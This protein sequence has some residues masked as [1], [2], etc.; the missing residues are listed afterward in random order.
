MT[1]RIRSI[2]LYGRDVDKVRTLTFRTSGLN[3]ITG[4][5]A[6][7]K[8]ALIDI[9]DYCLAS[10][11][12]NVP[13]GVIR[14]HVSK[15]ALEIETTQG[16][17][18]CA[19]DEPRQGK[20]TTSNMHIGIYD[21]SGPPDR[22]RLDPNMSLAA[23]RTLLSSLAD[24]EEN[25]TDSGESNR[26]EFA[27][28]IRHSLYF[29]FQG[30]GEIAD[31]RILFH[32]Q[33]QEFIPQAIRDVLPYFLGATDPSSVE[34]RARLR[35][36]RRELRDL[37]RLISDDER[38]SG[39][40][41]RAAALLSECQVLGMAA[42]DTRPT[43]A[44]QVIQTLASIAEAPIEQFDDADDQPEV[45]QQLLAE[46]ESLRGQLGEA[47]NE[48]S[49]L[50]ALLTAHQDFHVEADEQ[51]A[52]LQTIDLLRRTPDGET[53]TCPVCRSH[54]AE[55]VPSVEG[56]RNQL[57]RIDTEI[58]NVRQNT[59]NLQALLGET[60]ERVQELGEQ[61]RRNKSQLDE[62]LTT[63]QQLTDTRDLAIRRASARGRVSLYLES[64]S[65][66]VEGAFQRERL[67]ALETQERELQ[68]DLDSEEAQSRLDS[69]LARVALHIGNVVRSLKMEYADSPARLDI[70]K[71]TVIVDT[72]S[73]PAT[74][75]EL[76]SGANWLGYHLA[77]LIGLHR[78]FREQ[79]RPVPRFLILDQPSQVYYPQDPLTST[80]TVADEDSAAVERIFKSIYEFANEEPG[81]QVI[82]IDHA[83]LSAD[84]FQ[85][86]LCERWRDENKLIPLSWISR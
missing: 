35:S 78:F 17:Y 11:G 37:R 19:R 4:A 26:V 40:T 34:K 60:E 72:I 8:S 68:T 86:S 61:L 5:S 6:T 77:T 62:T 80:S 56:M 59:P 71:L 32:S 42:T 54:L 81:F 39:P 74:L 12:F 38:L 22:A 64:L 57:R 67:E 43:T 27:A 45:L 16:I 84:W 31:P 9:I 65:R 33:N 66:A 24:I 2:Y 70:T 1:L 79:N 58:S 13:T 82:L 29:T 49:N 18:V 50:R 44:D 20:G 15:Y 52:R 41:G 55:N 76:G 7:G 48:A 23:A 51:R 21:G 53:A 85:D 73:G 3:I 83:D 10:G 46:R 28:T 14:R 30:Q 75:A 69:A 63:Q 25:I 36:V 47:R